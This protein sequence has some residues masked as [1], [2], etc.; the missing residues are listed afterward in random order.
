MSCLFLSAFLL[1][2]VNCLEPDVV[3][4]KEI[5]SD[6]TNVD[7]LPPRNEKASSRLDN[8]A[9]IYFRDDQ[10]FCNEKAMDISCPAPKGRTEIC[11][12]ARFLFFLYHN[13][14]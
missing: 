14:T 2:R 8:L 5:D 9:N 12:Q 6:G 3:V 13:M 11:S 7:F 10:D 1:F 4:A